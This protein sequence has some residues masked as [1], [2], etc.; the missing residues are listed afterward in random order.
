MIGDLADINAELEEVTVR[1]VG[2]TRAGPGKADTTNPG[3]ASL[4]SERRDVSLLFI[5]AR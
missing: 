3:R 2:I 4:R 5:P 1:G